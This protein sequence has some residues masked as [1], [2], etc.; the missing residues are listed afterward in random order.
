MSKLII[1]LVGIIITCITIWSIYGNG[2][3]ELVVVGHVIMWILYFTAQGVLWWV[4]ADQG[5]QDVY[6]DVMSQRRL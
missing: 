1:S 3:F 2:D 6:Q 4:V 5:K